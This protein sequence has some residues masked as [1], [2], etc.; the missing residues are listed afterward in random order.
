MLADPEGN[1]FCVI[2]ARQQVPG[3][4]RVRGGA[5]VRRVAG[6]RIL[7]E[8]GAGVAAGVGPGTRRRRS[9]RRT[10]GRRSRGVGRRW[11][12]RPARNRLHFDLT[13]VELDSAGPLGAT[14]IGEAPGAGGHGR[15]RRE[16]VLVVG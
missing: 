15:P 6:G 13:H 7:L 14:R 2:G 5:R 3:R 1:E 10:A 8:R 12:P 16:R 9:G 11:I 4:V